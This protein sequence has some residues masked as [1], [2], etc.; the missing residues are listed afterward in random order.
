M[1]QRIAAIVAARNLPRKKQRTVIGAQERSVGELRWPLC[2]NNK[3]Q[4]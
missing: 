2:S 1:L 3:E 4:S